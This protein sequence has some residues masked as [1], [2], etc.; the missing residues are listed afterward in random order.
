MAEDAVLLCSERFDRALRTEV[1]IV[2]PEPHHP[3]PQCLEG[4]FEEQ[5]LAE[6]IDTRALMAAPVPRVADLDAI[7]RGHDV[8]VARAA[9]D[10]ATLQITNHPG[11]HVTVTLPFERVG[12][13]SLHTIG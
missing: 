13:V 12:D 1:E 3:A 8:V 7:D 11:Q 4:V 2:G 10:P 6:R 9:D 5:E